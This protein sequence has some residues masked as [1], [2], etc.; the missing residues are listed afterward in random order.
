MWTTPEEY[1]LIGQI[2]AHRRRGNLDKVA[3]LQRD[4]DQLKFIRHIKAQV[5]KAPPLTE[6]TKA[7]LSAVFADV[8]KSGGER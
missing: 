5:D 7:A 4:L 1:K 3:Q 6:D 8:L 2:R